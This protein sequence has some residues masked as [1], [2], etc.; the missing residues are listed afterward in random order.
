MKRFESV[1]YGLRFSACM[2]LTFIG[3]RKE[4]RLTMHKVL[5]DSYYVKLKDLQVVDFVLDELTLYLDTHPDDMQAIGQY[6]QF[7]S[8]RIGMVQEF[9]MEFGP[10][11]SNGHSFSK[12]PW[13]WNAAPWP[14]QV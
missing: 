9:E 3:S 12:S 13:E 6:N 1:H 2:S 8:K 14:W 10:L 7:A 5:P 4:G 11:M